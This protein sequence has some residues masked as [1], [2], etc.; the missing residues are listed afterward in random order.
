TPE[1]LR[2]ASI[3]GLGLR[4]FSIVLVSVSVSS[5]GSESL[6]RSPGVFNC[7]VCGSKAIRGSNRINIGLHSIAILFSFTSAP[8]DGAMSIHQEPRIILSEHSNPAGSG[9]EGPVACSHVR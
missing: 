9:H 6:L 3:C 7:G 5:L 8:E 2:V 4:S 1:T